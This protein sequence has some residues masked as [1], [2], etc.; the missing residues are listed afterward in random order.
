M[1]KRASKKRERQTLLRQ[2][3]KATVDITVVVDGVGMV[4]IIFILLLKRIRELDASIQPDQYI[5]VDEVVCNLSVSDK[6]QFQ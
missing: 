2:K 6:H 3:A 1:H 5:F 4:N